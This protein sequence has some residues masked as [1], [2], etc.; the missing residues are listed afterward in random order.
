MEFEINPI[1]PAELPALLE[2]IRELAAF[3]K[4]EHEVEATL[5]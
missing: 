2:L 5:V 3:E 4:L 1:T